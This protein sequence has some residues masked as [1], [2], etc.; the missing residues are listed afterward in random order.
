MDRVPNWKFCAK[1]AV[2]F[3]IGLVSISRSR[4]DTLDDLHKKAVK[5]GIVSFYGTLAQVNA[6][7]ILPVFEP[8]AVERYR[9]ARGAPDAHLLRSLE[10][11]GGV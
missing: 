6:E 4:A 7:K 3:L 8:R 1:L 10:A 5:E 9:R 11:R 2:I